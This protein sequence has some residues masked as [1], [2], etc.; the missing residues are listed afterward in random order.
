[1]SGDGNCGIYSIMEGL[2]HNN[3]EF[4]EDVDIFRISIV[5]YIY[6]NRNQVL[7]G[8]EFRNK[9]IFDGTMRGQS[10]DNFIDT[11]VK[12][13]IWNEHTI[14]KGGYDSDC[15]VD[16]NHVFPIIAQKYQINLVW[17]TMI[18]KPI[19]ICHKMSK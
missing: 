18:I 15:W 9:R 17:Y 3:I 16:S 14:F 19:N 6:I 4:N 8:I 12:E 11:V 1:M 5:D 7:Q 2:Y 10:R 13:R